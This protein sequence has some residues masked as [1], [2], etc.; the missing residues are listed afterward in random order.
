LWTFTC[1]L[2]WGAAV[3]SNE[4]ILVVED[5]ADIAIEIQS[6]L[7]AHGYVIVGDASSGERAIELAVKHQPDL[8]L[9][10][11]QLE[12]RLD[13]VDAAQQL[14]EQLDIPVLYMTAHAESSTVAR[15]KATGPA[16]YLL[17]PFSERELAV[18]VEM[19]LLR[20]QLEASLRAERERLNVT[21]LSIGEGVIATDVDARVVLLN[22]VAEEL[23][24]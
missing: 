22:R 5:D 14:R 21:L 8:V 9:M 19:A 1:K 7:A 13:G 24:G 23:T 17:K 3:M 18:A 12:G 20:H 15:A 10:D 16:G 2:P 11:I 6:S 4:R